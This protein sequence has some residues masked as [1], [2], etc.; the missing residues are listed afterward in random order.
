MAAN[1]RRMWF[2]TS[3]PA[4][5][6]RLRFKPAS[7]QRQTWCRCLSVDSNFFDTVGAQVEL[8]RTFLPSDQPPNQ[9]RAIILSHSRHQGAAMTSL[10]P[11]DYTERLHLLIA[12][13]PLED[14]TYASWADQFSVSTDYFEVMRIP[15]RRGRLFTA[16][17]TAT[18]PRVAL[19]NEAC[20]RTRFLGE[21]PIGKHIQLGRPPCRRSSRAP[22]GRPSTRWPR[23]GASRPGAS[24]PVCLG[25]AGMLGLRRGH[26]RSPIPAADPSSADPLGGLHGHCLTGGAKAGLR[27][28]PELP[29]LR[30]GGG[31][32]RGWRAFWQMRSSS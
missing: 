6:R 7:A 18:T 20:A 5:A 10:I 11:M 24:T 3:R 25:C 21:N 27:D 16:Q 26:E 19:I 15:L 8:G 23:S 28:I 30:A 31:P 32:S 17:D 14:E 4:A 13:H 2:A 29:S 22:R 12:E 1:P 9:R